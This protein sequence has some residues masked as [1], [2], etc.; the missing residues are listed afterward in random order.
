MGLSIY[1]D[2]KFSELE[3][4]IAYL[5]KLVRNTGGHTSLQ[6]FGDLVGNSP[7]SS[8]CKLKLNAM[9]GYGFLEVLAKDDLKVTPLGEMVAAP[10]DPFEF[11]N[12]CITALSNFPVFSSLTNKYKGRG[13]PEPQ[14]VENAI[15]TEGLVPQDKA[16]AWAECF[17]KSA[18]QA[19]LFGARP[20]FENQKLKDLEFQGAGEVP[21]LPPPPGGDKPAGHS[22]LSLDEKSKGWLTYPVVVP[23]GRA[24]IIVPP[25]LSWSAWDKLK[26]LLDAIEPDKE[27]GK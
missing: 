1:I 26:K 2:P 17:L 5:V 3:A 23:E 4:S 13:E 10:R 22:D 24:R 19:N 6:E 8:Y 12:G 7:S 15:R 21:L 11:E 25:T 16:R 20:A 27:A 9:K 18:R 14:Y